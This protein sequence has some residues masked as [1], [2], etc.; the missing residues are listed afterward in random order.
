MIEIPTA[1]VITKKNLHLCR[2]G[3]F[4][5]GHEERQGVWH[6]FK[7]SYDREDITKAITDF[8]KKESAL[9]DH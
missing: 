3:K 9:Y 7:S 6:F 4:S 8:V 2:Y 1:G 5:V